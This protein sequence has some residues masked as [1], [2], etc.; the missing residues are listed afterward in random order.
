[1]SLAAFSAA[2]I[3]PRETIALVTGKDRSNF[4]TGETVHGREVPGHVLQL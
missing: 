3:T 1:M 4:T 2:P